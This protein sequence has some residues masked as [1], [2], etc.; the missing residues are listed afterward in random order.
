V[1]EKSRISEV[2]AAEQSQHALADLSH[3]RHNHRRDAGRH[4]GV[5]DG[6]GTAR[7]PGKTG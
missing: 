7:V 1:Q 2:D 4:Q 3:N 5:F 6:G